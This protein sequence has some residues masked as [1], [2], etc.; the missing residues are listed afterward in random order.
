MLV[1]LIVSFNQAT[2]Q[3][4]AAPTTNGTKEYTYGVIVDCGS[5]GTRAHIFEWDSA[6][7]YPALLNDIE[8]LRDLDGK[9]FTMRIR[10]GLSS[11]KDNPD[12]ASDYMQPILDFITSKIPEESHQRTGIYILG[13]A[14]MRLLNRKTKLKIMDD[15]AEHIKNNYGFAR[16]R[17][18]V[19]SGAA[20]GM[21]QWI[22]VNSKA[23]RFATASSSHQP[24]GVIEMGGASLQ[25]TYKLNRMDTYINKTLLKYPGAQ[26][27]FQS[28]IVTPSISRNTKRYNYTLVSTTFLGLGSNSAREA[29]VDLLV[30]N[31]E[32]KHRD[33]F[34]V[35]NRVLKTNVGKYNKAKPLD[36]KDPC[37]PKGA[38]QILLKPTK[39]LRSPE[40]TVGFHI[41]ENDDTFTVRLSGSGKYSLCQRYMKK[42]LATVKEEKMNCRNNKPCTMSLIGTPF[43][44]FKNFDFFGL[45]DFYY[46]TNEM[47]N[48]AGK[49]D[50]RKIVNKSKTICQTAYKKLLFLYKQA[51]RN[52]KSRVLLECFKA[53]WM[54]TFLTDGLRM[55]TNYN[56]FETIGKIKGDSIDWT[57]GAVLEKSLTI[58][59]ASDSLEKKLASE[60]KTSERKR[61]SG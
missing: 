24:Y 47:L 10:P 56:K 8:P 17:T 3:V 23:K 33:W 11:L 15:I 16:V 46:T 27:A 49:Y 44:P 35:I 43:V 61:K 21:F 57:L 38:T 30:M 60:K 18:N 4:D 28:Q 26:E 51:N 42:M 29:Y 45:G 54:D 50:R 48:L 55:P 59:L 2:A 40:K 37:L 41:S 5:S 58:E 7:D 19:I 9:P 32:H 20:E 1:C 6:L 39:M 12:K 36:L 13:T 53:V 52:D 14:G 34:N 22:T 31:A 25:V